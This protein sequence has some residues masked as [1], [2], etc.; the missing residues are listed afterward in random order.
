MILNCAKFDQYSF[1]MNAY[2]Y[3]E[4][5]FS[6]SFYSCRRCVCQRFNPI[7]SIRRESTVLLS[8]PTSAIECIVVRRPREYARNILSVIDIKVGQDYYVDF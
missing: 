5:F 2:T 1:F 3:D 6:L 7:I 8:N 4:R